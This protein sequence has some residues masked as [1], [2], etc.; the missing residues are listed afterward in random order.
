MSRTNLR[1]SILLAL[2]IISQQSVAA[3]DASAAKIYKC[4][5]GGDTLY[6]DEKCP[7]AAQTTELM[8]E[9]TSGGFVSPDAATIAAS[10]AQMRS[11]TPS[12]GTAAVI[13]K[14]PD[15]TATDVQWTCRKL[16]QR[17]NKIDSASHI[18]A[19]RK[20]QQKLK[21]ERKQLAAKQQKLKC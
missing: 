5:S 14:K 1:F 10:M 18:N 15:R 11:D 12:D 8:I 20:S 16:A 9:D 17:I 2:I 19:S 21:I 7:S 3:K 6:S 4:Q 13:G